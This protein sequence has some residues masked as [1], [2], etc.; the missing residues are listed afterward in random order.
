MDQNTYWISG[1]RTLE[2]QNFDKAAYSIV[3]VGRSIN[4]FGP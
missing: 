2:G 3:D 1:Q 4:G